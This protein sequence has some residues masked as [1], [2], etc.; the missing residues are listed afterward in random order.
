MKITESS[1]AGRDHQCDLHPLEFALA[2]NRA[3]SEAFD[4]TILENHD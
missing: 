1:P 2:F 4:D 3:G